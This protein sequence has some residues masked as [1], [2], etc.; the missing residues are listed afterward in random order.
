MGWNRGYTIFEATVVGAYDLGKLDKALLGVLMEPY[1]G[2]DIDSGGEVGLSAKD[3][4]GIREIVIKTWGAEPPAKPDGF[5]KRWQD[6]SEIERAACD[7]YWDTLGEMFS[8]ITRE[9]GW[10]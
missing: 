3:G 6:R 8:E 2:S 5:D 4:L 1:R 9:F 10:R 7:D